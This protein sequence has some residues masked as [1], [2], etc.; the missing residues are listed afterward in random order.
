MLRK[1]KLFPS[2][3]FGSVRGSTSASLKIGGILAICQK[4]EIFFNVGSHLPYFL[5]CVDRLIT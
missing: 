5:S 3:K 1:T 4:L 2:S